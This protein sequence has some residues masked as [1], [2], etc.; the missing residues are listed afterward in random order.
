MSRN[1]TKPTSLYN[2]E[3]KATHR[4]SEEHSGTVV[5]FSRVAKFTEICSVKVADIYYRKS[6]MSRNCTKPTSLY[7]YEIK[8]THR[9]SEE[10]SGTVVIFSRVAKFTKI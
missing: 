8:A 3:I 4:P 9:P 1:C 7:N 6:P 10:H 2:Y 5:I